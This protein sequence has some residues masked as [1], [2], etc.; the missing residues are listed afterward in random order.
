MDQIDLKHLAKNISRINVGFAGIA[1]DFY[2]KPVPENACR[3]DHDLDNAMMMR[4]F[5]EHPRTKL[6]IRHVTSKCEG[7]FPAR[8]LVD[9]LGKFNYRGFA[10][11]D[12]GNAF[13]T[14]V[15]K[16]QSCSAANAARGACDNSDFILNLHAGLRGPLARQARCMPTRHFNPI[17][18]SASSTLSTKVIQR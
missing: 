2:S 8:R 11:V 3:W 4:G 13:D 9:L 6:G 14:L 10:E 12:Q 15:D 18:C 16:L 1:L 7:Q 5:V 17:C